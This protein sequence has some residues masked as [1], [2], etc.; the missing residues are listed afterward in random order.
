MKSI[1]NELWQGN[2]MPQEDPQT[3]SAD[4]KEL[5]VYVARHHKDLEKSL[6]DEQ[7]EIFEKFQ[8]CWTEYTNLAEA[9]AFEYGFKLGMRFAIE[10]LKNT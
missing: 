4:M 3:N 1:I 5:L 8:E 9:A 2:L 10:S 7:K 6:N